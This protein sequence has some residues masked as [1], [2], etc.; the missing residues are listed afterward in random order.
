M[1]TKELYRDKKDCCGCEACAQI[2]PMNIIEMRQD[3]EGF[4]YPS[5]I[6]EDRCIHCDRCKSICPLKNPLEKPRKIRKNFAGYNKDESIIKHCASGGFAYTLSTLFIEKGGV[7][8]GVRYSEKN[9]RDIE[10]TRCATK[11]QL[12]PTCGSKYAQSR[13]NDVFKHVK[14]D[15]R[16]GTD[17]LFFGLPCEVAALY[18]FLGKK[19]EN[20]FTVDLICHG[21]T[22]QRVH[23]EFVDNLLADCGKRYITFFSVRHKLAA[24][25]PYYIHA[26]FDDN[27]THD[28]KF[29]DTDYGVAFQNLKRPS[30]AKCRFKVY[31]KEYGMPADLTIG[32]YHLASTGMPQYN[33][34][35]SSQVSSHSEKGDYLIEISQTQM[36]L[37][38]I[39]EKKAVHY[40][41]AFFRPAHMRWNRPL[42]VLVLKKGGVKLACRHW[43]V[44]ITNYF[45][46]MK[47]K[48]VGFIAKSIVKFRNKG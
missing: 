45:V 18:H 20:L 8:Y 29:V 1:T 15:L 12:L 6:D 44:R 32:D 33:H 42:F 10:Y 22:S 36:S 47:R 23:S 2:C 46:E 25:K 27:T 5:I 39:S 37:T 19:N 48:C 41:A 13:K 34:W 11:D 24:W 35:G 21:P 43:S 7:V 3:H 38:P 26:V 40:N 30:C 17:V 16:N 14:E 31:D 4:F 28:I 9:V